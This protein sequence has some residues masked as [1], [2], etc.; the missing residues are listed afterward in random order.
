MT[1][2]RIAWLAGLAAALAL[3]TS[4]TY[5]QITNSGFENGFTSGVANGWSSFASSGYSPSFAD[6]TEH[7]LSGSHAQ[8]VTIPSGADAYGGITQTFS[9]T[10]GKRYRIQ[11]WRYRVWTGEEYNVLDSISVDRNGGTVWN[12]PDN[13]LAEIST[14]PNEWHQV[15]IEVRSDTGS[16]T[17]WLR[18][19]FKYAIG[20]TATIWWDDISIQDVTP[21]TWSGCSPASHSGWEDFEDLP[22]P[23]DSIIAGNFSTHDKTGGNSDG[24]TYF[25]FGEGD[26]K[27]LFDIKGPGAVVD[28]WFTGLYPVQQLEFTFDDAST[29]EIDMPAL[30]FFN[31][32]TCRWIDQGEVSWTSYP[33]DPYIDPLN[34]GFADAGGGFVSNIRMPFQSRGRIANENSLGYYA[35][36]YHKYE[37]GTTVDTFDAVSDCAELEFLADV[38]DDPSVDPKST[39]GNAETSGTAVITAG[40]TVELASLSGDGYIA[41]IYIDPSPSTQAALQNTWLDIRFDDR[42]SNVF[43]PIGY[44]FGCGFE[45]RNVN[46]MGIGMSTTGDYYCYFPMPYWESAVVNIVNQGGSTMT[47][48]YTVVYNGAAYDRSAGYFSAIWA[49]GNNFELNGS[50]TYLGLVGT[51]DGATSEG[52]SYL[53]GDERI[54]IDGDRWNTH[55]GTGTEDFFHGGWYYETGEFSNATHGAPYIALNLDGRDLHSQY[56]LRPIDFIP[57]RTSLMFDLELAP[58]KATYQLVAYAYQRPFDSM[59]LTDYLEIADSSSE[60]AHSYSVTGQTWSGGFTSRFEGIFDGDDVNS[61]GR[62]FTGTSTFDVDIDDE[63]D[64]VFLRRLL[65]QSTHG[66]EADVYVDSVYVGRWYTAGENQNFRWKEDGFMIPA[67][68][69]YGKSSITIDIENAN[70]SVPFSEF[71]YEVFSRYFFYTH[72]VHVQGEDQ[73]GTTTSGASAI[74]EDISTSTSRWA[75]DRHLRYTGSTNNWVQIP[76]SVPATGQYLVSMGVTAAS[77]CGHGQVSIDG[78]NIG[79]DISFAAD[80]TCRRTE[81]LGIRQLSAGTRNVRVTVTS[82]STIGIDDIML[83]K[84]RDPGAPP[85]N[86]PPTAVASADPTSGTAPLAVD[87]DGTDSSDPDSDTL[88]Y[89][90]DWDDGSAHGSGSTPSHTFTNVGTYNVVL[91]VDDGND[92]TD[93]DTVVITANAAGPS[94]VNG[95]FSDGLTGWS[96]WTDRGTITFS[97]DSNRG[98]ISGNNINGGLYQQFSTGG[99]DTEID[100]TGWWATSPATANNQW[101]EVLIINGDRNPSNG[102]DIN[103]GQS[104]V[105]LIYKND[106]WTSTS[107]WSGD[108]DQTAPVTNVGTFTADDTVA[109]IILKMGNSGGSTNGLL[110]DN[111]VVTEASGSSP[112]ISLNKSSLS[113]SCTAG[114]SPSNDT[115]TVTNSGGETLDY[116]VTDNQTWLSGSPTSGT[117]TGEADTI[118]VTYSTAGL[119]VGTHYAT[120]SVTDTGATNSPQTIAVTL[121]V[122]ASGG[123]TVEEDFGSM[124]TWSTSFDASWGSAATWSIDSSGQS[125]N[126]LKATRSS[127]GSSAKVKVYTIDAN[128]SY[129]ISV[130]IRCPSS[131]TTYWSE[132]A[133]KLG[134]YTANNFDDSPGTWTMVKK[135]DNSGTN[136]NGDTW[137]QYSVNFNS[138]SYTQISVGY[139]L[140]SSGGAG[141]TVRWDTLRVE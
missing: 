103:G 7:V 140:G 122:S 118:T 97:N 15:S 134:S 70:T 64:G 55:Y 20:G 126:C 3:C 43:V 77:D 102:S 28:L 52:R 117:S 72:D 39:S 101:G 89:D 108:M 18:T 69:T 26:Q 33:V 41:A 120:I 56:R 124:P 121:T 131:G 99:V 44:F 130:Y 90:W 24:Y 113:P 29:P 129:T 98:K 42:A 48:P 115:F 83:S 9:V 66:Q 67:Q 95:D 80:A 74:S 47:I 51:A 87:F 114:S 62:K 19:Q 104:D 17:I 57:Y 54:H 5:G 135:F 31:G 59:E 25:P 107:G 2:Q 93:T 86:L 82:G 34:R 10:E 49:P 58:G 84:V 65:D 45:E 11:A 73:S 1:R 12:E 75:G 37:P 21:P 111:L 32:E 53:E 91:T 46:A 63:N 112:T 14:K 106:T 100:I 76:V 109:T 132:C 71:Y 110:F 40:N 119:D 139:K 141:P 136:G 137:T 6:G 92:G 50:G 35:G 13:F 85:G 94:L 79:P 4:A 8:K 88:T 81:Y 138:G 23:K 133:C 125:G 128:T 68:Y 116:T 123:T 38:F 60:S 30:E 16:I 61:Y 22:L 105:E 36:S 96:Q 27:V 78:T 127:G